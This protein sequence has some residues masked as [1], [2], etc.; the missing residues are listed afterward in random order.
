MTTQK[1]EKRK[2]ICCPFCEEEIMT[3]DLPFCQACKVTLLLCP[4]CRQPIV[5]DDEV[6]PHC[7]TEIPG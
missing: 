5:R 3:A 1:D 7:G 6:C 4:E 2:H